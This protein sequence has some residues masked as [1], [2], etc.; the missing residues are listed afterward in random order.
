[1]TLG[2]I[3]RFVILCGDF[4]DGLF[5]CVRRWLWVVVKRGFYCFYWFFCFRS[6]L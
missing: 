3:F 2:V 1:M 5:F 6:G 4:K